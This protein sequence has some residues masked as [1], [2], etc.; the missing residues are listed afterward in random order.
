MDRDRYRD[1]MSIE[2][3]PLSDDA[4]LEYAR[5]SKRYPTASIA[6]QECARRGQA[7]IDELEEFLAALKYADVSQFDRVKGD[8]SK[9]LRKG[10]FHIRLIK[11]ARAALEGKE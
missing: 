9:L 2:Q 5:K 8:A 4:F 6:W 11:K 1:P 3:D 10:N 7:R